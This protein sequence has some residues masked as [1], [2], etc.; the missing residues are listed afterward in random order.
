MP[1]IDVPLSRAG[2]FRF[3]GF[4]RLLH[5]GCS[6]GAAFQVRTVSLTVLF[7]RIVRPCSG[8]VWSEPKLDACLGYRGDAHSLGAGRLSSDVLLLPRGVLQGFL[9]GSA[10]VH[11]R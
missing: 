11:R 5:M 3:V 2:V 1:Q 7:A 4:H 9:G 8:L 6:A 10:F